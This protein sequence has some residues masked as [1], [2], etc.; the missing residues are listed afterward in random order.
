MAHT[1]NR[2]LLD[3]RLRDVHAAPGSVRSRKG[4]SGLDEGEIFERSPRDHA[5]VKMVS[6]HEAELAFEEL[7]LPR[8]TGRSERRLTEEE[9]MML[10]GWRCLDGFLPAA[11][12]E[13]APGEKGSAIH[14][15]QDA[16][17]KLGG[18]K[19]G[20]HGCTG[21]ESWKASMSPDCR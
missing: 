9:Q 12:H 13:L 11:A 2:Q 21:P 5:V 17:E 20:I 10:E 19:Y 1:E 18:G 7:V 6:K 4:L 3:C 15:Q 16:L 8:R 14:C